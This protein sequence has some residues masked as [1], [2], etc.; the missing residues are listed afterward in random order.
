M[1]FGFGGRGD[2]SREIAERW[3][4][5]T[6][7][8]LPIS[9]AP[10]TSQRRQEESL[11]ECRRASE[12]RALESAQETTKIGEPASSLTTP[13][14]MPEVETRTVFV[15]LESDMSSVHTP[16]VCD[17]HARMWSSWRELMTDGMLVYWTRAMGRQGE[18][19]S[20][21]FARE[22]QMK[23]ADDDIID[24]CELR[25]LDA[26]GPAQSRR[27][28]RRPVGR[29]PAREIGVRRYRMA[30]GVTIDPGAADNVM[31]RRMLR[32][33]CSKV[34]SSA[35]SRAG[36]HCVAANNGRIRNEGEA[37]LHFTSNEG[38]VLVWTFQIAEVN[39][40]LASV[41][42]L[43]DSNHRVVF[44]K[45][46]KTGADISFITDKSTNVSTKM[47]RERNVWVVDAWVEEDAPD[48]LNVDFVRRE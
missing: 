29:A 41:S 1:R 12:S 16:M 22:R 8:A 36:V 44:D 4:C 33:K 7:V 25:D 24:D 26:V 42:A 34:R 14:A 17:A 11:P 9:R 30:R 47:R 20:D 18:S 5:S 15:P 31:P 39:K 13:V 46:K 19:I 48:D 43:V 3:N 40:V 2:P 28:T 32:G 37:D 35:A 38:N 21:V 27:T 6:R 23:R 10:P 45:D